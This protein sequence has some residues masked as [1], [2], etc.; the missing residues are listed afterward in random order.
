MELHSLNW[1]VSPAWKLSAHVSHGRERD[2][3]DAHDASRTSSDGNSDRRRDHELR[4]LTEEDKLSEQYM[5]GVSCPRCYEKLT[6]EQKMRFAERQKQI[7]LA[8]SLLHFKTALT[9]AASKAE[10]N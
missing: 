3:T 6:D 7:Q 5:P 9:A 4:E 1:T 8:K 10:R 2:T